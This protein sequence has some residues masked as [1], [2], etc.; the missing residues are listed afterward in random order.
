MS[1]GDKMQ[2]LMEELLAQ[3]HECEWLEFKENN[4]DKQEIGEYISALANSAALLG[5][6]NA[7]VVWGIED[8][9]HKVVGTTFK[10]QN[11]KVGSQALEMWLTV[12]LHPRIDFA[13]H[14]IVFEGRPVVVLVSRPITHQP[15]RFEDTE[16]IRV[17][18]HKTKLKDH[19]AKE[20]QLWQLSSN[21]NFED[22][23][24][25]ERATAED[26]LQ[27]LNYQKYFALSGL[28]VPDQAGI[29]DRLVKENFFDTKE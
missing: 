18:S 28:T 24:A 22:E 21:R 1:G 19:P 14:E 6:P 15:V 13:F 17:G 4:F 5:K 29:I 2:L 12:R 3:S 27:L 8:G 25:T 10:P 16:F 9:T 7:Y 20:R 11:E 23:I 26:V